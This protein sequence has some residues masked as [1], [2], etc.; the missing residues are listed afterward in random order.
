MKKFI[1]LILAVFTLSFADDNPKAVIN[2]TTPDLK[3]LRYTF[4]GR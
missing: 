3:D 4:L 2:L 1:F